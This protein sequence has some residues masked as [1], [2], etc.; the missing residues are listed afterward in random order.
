MVYYMLLGMKKTCLLFQFHDFRI[1][2]F[3]NK[4]LHGKK[5]SKFVF[6]NTGIEYRNST[7]CTL[8]ILYAILKIRLQR[9]ITII[10]HE[11]IKLHKF[12]I[13]LFS[14]NL[15]LGKYGLISPTSSKQQIKISRRMRRVSAFQISSKL[16]PKIFTNLN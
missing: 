10:D 2:I 8:L 5:N 14:S 1:V 15:R 11:E 13:P 3:C 9:G 6:R 7:K 12:Y 16:T 4:F